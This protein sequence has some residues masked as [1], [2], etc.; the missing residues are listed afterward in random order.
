MAEKTAPEAGAT[1][2]ISAQRIKRALSHRKQ[3]RISKNA[4]NTSMLGVFKLAAAIRTLVIVA[5]IAYVVVN[6]LPHISLDFIFGWPR[7]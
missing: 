1:E 6:G 4:S 7:A 3:C 2:L 5:I